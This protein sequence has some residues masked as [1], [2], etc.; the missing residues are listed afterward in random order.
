MFGVPALFLDDEAR[1]TFG[2]LIDRRQA[3][4]VCVPDLVAH[5]LRLPAAQDRPIH[6]P[7]PIEAT[8]DRLETMACAF[9]RVVRSRAPEADFDPAWVGS[10]CSLRGQS[11]IEPPLKAHRSA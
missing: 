7:P 2:R 6:R 3:R 9:G 5:I 10:R 1:E 8:L 11:G 4:V